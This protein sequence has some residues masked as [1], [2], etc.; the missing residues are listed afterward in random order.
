MKYRI[1]GD[2][3]WN[4]H[5]A[6]TNYVSPDFR[7]NNTIDNGMVLTTKRE[8]DDDI[9]EELINIIHKDFEFELIK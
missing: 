7:I 6:L 1:K 9:A 2:F 4:D 8:L 5:L 3:T